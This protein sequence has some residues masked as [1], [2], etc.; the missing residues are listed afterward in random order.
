M[1]QSLFIIV[2]TFLISQNTVAFN[3]SNSGLQHTSDSAK[4][5][6]WINPI[7]KGLNNFGQKDF[8]ITETNGKYYL[9]ATEYPDPSVGKR[10]VILYVSDDLF[11]WKEGKV[12]IDA[13]RIPDTAWYKNEF[14]APEIHEFKGAF[15]LVFTARNNEK[16][17]YGKTSICIAKSGRIDGDYKVL[18]P[19]K[20]LIEGYNPNIFIEGDDIYLYYDLDG[21]VYGGIFDLNK[22]AFV[23]EQKPIIGPGIQKDFRFSDSPFV[24]KHQ[25]IYYLMYWN[26]KGGYV[27]DC[28]FLIS[29]KPLGRFKPVKNN[30]VM[31]FTEDEAPNKLKMVYPKNKPFAPP[32]QVIGHS[33]I[34]ITANGNAFI[35]YNSSEK[36]AEPYL[37]IEPVQLSQK[38][39]KV[40]HHKQAKQTIKL[41]NE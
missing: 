20:G 21:I 12:L 33:Q 32:T 17:F 34:L 30:L 24:Y 28:K 39:I 9:V 27:L 23:N 22:A 8:H 1:K 10:G 14:L 18:N 35:V 37:V 19:D 2:L 36:Y 15:Y 38:A 3:T 4:T 41:N 13:N 31:Q 25:G 29:E 16:K 7:T 11:N 5:V 26:F 6:D 40:I